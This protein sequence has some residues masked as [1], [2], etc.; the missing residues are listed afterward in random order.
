MARVAASDVFVRLAL[1][2]A[3]DA[4]HRQF[5]AAAQARAARLKPD[6]KATEVQ[7]FVDGV[8]GRPVEAVKPFG[9]I[10]WRLGYL[11]SIARAA[12]QILNETS[13]VDTG[14]YKREHTLFV[15]GESVS[16]VDAIQ[17]GTR[18]FVISNDVPY[19]R[20]VEVGKNNQ[21]P[22]SS[23]PQV[24]RQGVYKNAASRI[25]QRYGH[26]ANIEFTWVGLDTGSMLAGAA[27]NVS[28]SRF[29]AI[30]VESR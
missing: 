5:V 9:V 24:P 4:V 19:A 8:E 11:R 25:R 7:Q 21:V 3:E 10:H 20:V 16:D 30:V 26:L 2:G 6:T 28:G 22:W 29:P 17:D 12:L 23:Q 13:P 15:D 18:R 27:A 1:K 14:T